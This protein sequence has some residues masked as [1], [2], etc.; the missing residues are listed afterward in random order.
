VP[1]APQRGYDSAFVSAGRMVSNRVLMSE[2]PVP[3]SFRTLTESEISEVLAVDVP[4]RLATLDSQGYPYITPLWYLFQDGAF[5]MTSVAGRPHLR[6]IAR[7][8]RAQV[9]VDL[10]SGRA[11]DGQRA[12]ARVRGRG[13]A[14]VFP[15][16]GGAWTRR[17]TL[18]YV[19]GEQGRLQADRRAAMD[20]YVIRLHPERLIAL[21]TPP[22]SWPQ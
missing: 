4:A 6:H 18:R 14:E 15:D 13:T 16:P 8:R 9:C 21:G 17:I 10:E 12:N 3:P 20:R 11:V 1:D 7:D 2:R 19:P 5:I 22:S